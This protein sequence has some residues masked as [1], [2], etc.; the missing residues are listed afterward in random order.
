MKPQVVEEEQDS[1]KECVALADT[2]VDSGNDTKKKAIVR[3]RL[4]PVMVTQCAMIEGKCS[5]PDDKWF[6]TRK[7]EW[8]RK[9]LSALG[10]RIIEL[11]RVVVGNCSF[12]KSRAGNNN[13]KIHFK[14][15]SQLGFNN[16]FL[17]LYF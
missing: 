8:A 9:V 6:R 2:V 17:F 10:G 16:S 11:H 15:V 14:L 7:V 3:M 4:Q 5:E 13:K 1:K 12:L